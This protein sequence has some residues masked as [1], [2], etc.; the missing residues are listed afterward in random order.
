MHATILGNVPGEGVLY[1]FKSKDGLIKEE[2]ETFVGVVDAELFEAISFK[3]LKFENEEQSI[4]HLYLM[5]A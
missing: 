4:S 2:L 5:T 3:V 1:L